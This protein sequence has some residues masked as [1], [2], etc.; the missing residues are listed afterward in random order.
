MTF[1][2]LWG[3]DVHFILEIGNVLSLVV[4]EMVD[5]ILFSSWFSLFCVL[6]IVQVNH[7][8]TELYLVLSFLHA[9]M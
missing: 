1:G 9:S 4:R 5:D 7:S 2:T 3:D 8:A 6:L